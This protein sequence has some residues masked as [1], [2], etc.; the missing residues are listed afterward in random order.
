M[1]YKQVTLEMLGPSA[2]AC[3]L[4]AVR[5]LMNIEGWGENGYQW[6]QFSDREQQDCQE[7]WERDIQHFI[8]ALDI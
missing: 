5:H 1:K 2:T 8:D 3:D 4:F 7:A 6:E